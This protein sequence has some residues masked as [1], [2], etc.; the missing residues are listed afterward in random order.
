MCRKSNHLISF[1][2]LVGLVLASA[3][4]ADLVGWW[5]LDDGSGTTA[6]DSSDSG[7]DG[8]L[9]GDPQW[10]AGKV[11][12]ALECDGGDYV[13]VPGVAN[14]NPQD[15]TLMTWVNFTTVD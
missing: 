14:I 10:V 1:A 8:T 6:I 15:I 2:L 7:N 13:D 4:Q 12:G 5:K 9:Q 3:A 11:G